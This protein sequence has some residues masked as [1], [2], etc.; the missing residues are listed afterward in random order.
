VIT[1]SCPSCN[2]RSSV[3]DTYKGVRVNCPGCGTPFTVGDAAA[4]RP[5]EAH[6][7]TP[8]PVRRP[9]PPPPRPAPP[10]PKPVEA[11]APVP[12][13]RRRQPTPPPPAPSVFP[14]VVAAVGLAGAALLAAGVFAPLLD[15]PLGESV[16]YFQSGRWEAVLLLLLAAATAGLSLLRWHRG[17]WLTGL[18]AFAVVTVT[19]TRLLAALVELLRTFEGTPGAELGGVMDLVQLRWGWAV[20]LAGALV[21]VAAAVT[22]EVRRSVGIAIA[23]LFAIPLVLLLS[24]AATWGVTAATGPGGFSIGNGPPPIEPPPIEP[25]PST[26]RKPP[27]P[28]ETEWVDASKQ[29]IRLGDVRVRVTEVTID[30]VRGKDG[31]GEFVSSEKHLAVRVRLENLGDRRAITYDGW[32]TAGTAASD[33]VPR[34]HDDLGAACKRVTFGAGALA[35][36]QVESASVA[37]G[38]SVQDLL[39]FEPP[40]DATRPLRLELPARNFGGT[41]QVRFAIPREMVREGTTR[42]PVVDVGARSVP[43]LAKALKAGDPKERL[44]AANELGRRGPAAGGAVTALG[45]AVGDGDLSVRAASAEALGK[46]GILARPALPALLAALADSE[47]PVRKAARDAMAT[48]GFLRDDVSVLAD[49]LKHTSPAVRL[50]AVQAIEG[51]GADP[52]A[53]VPVYAVALKDADAEVRQQAARSLGKLGPK[54]RGRVLPLLLAARKD[55][56]AGVKSAAEEGLAALGP[57]AA[58]DLAA[59]RTAA[60]DSSPEVR[61]YALKG[62][63]GLG[64]AAKSAVPELVV[65]LEQPDKETRRLAAEALVKL[66][67]AAKDAA[68]PLTKALADPDPAVRAWA[69]EA[70]GG[71]GDAARPAVDKVGLALRDTDP[72][73]REAA[74][75][76]LAR[77]A[78]DRLVS[79][80]GRALLD[81]E[82]DVRREAAEALA[83]M[84]AGAKPALAN[85]IVAIDD[86][87]PAV[88]IKVARAIAQAEPDTTAPL[89]ALGELIQH[90]DEDIRREAAEAFALMQSVRRDDV[91]VLVAALKDKDLVVRQKVAETLTRMGRDAREAVGALIAALEDRKMHDAAGAALLKIGKE[92]VGPLAEA[93]K[94]KQ[95]SRRLGAAV[96]LG[97]FG[98]DAESAYDALS[99]A[100]YKEKDEEVGKAVGEARK[101]VKP[102]P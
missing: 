99:T 59:L 57:S 32:G 28:P 64:P 78:P 87:N 53:A 44:A 41:G 88:R 70:L 54:A 81:K 48:I 29:A 79:A 72:G 3:P 24:G 7:S 71:L 77:L 5:A 58:E 61:A 40:A 30:H 50:Y 23:G 20:L 36:G 26:G 101:R 15:V 65:A 17:L 83:K 67:P 76:A 85:L 8:P 37:P 102:E 11:E 62:I 13:A 56:D 51:T 91:P 66:G 39:L 80:Y 82:D 86:P 52:A 90:P 2:Y 68:A 46:V 100:W 18:A 69:V 4:A 94:D 33:Q 14:W 98:P 49:A 97:K 35:T 55:G 25:P 6:A 22:A 27:P 47:E 93:L 96:T 38:A 1:A 21:I 43:D 31:G 63:A 92:S 73:V 75:K 9:V 10:P 45:E 42:V 16:S 34:L 84:G 95:A 74:G 60:K 89:K 19:F 12:V